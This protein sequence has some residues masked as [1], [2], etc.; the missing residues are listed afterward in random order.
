MTSKVP[1]AKVTENLKEKA[2]AKARMLAKA[3]LKATVPEVRA[4]SF[5]IKARV[6]METLA[7]LVTIPRT[8]DACL[9]EL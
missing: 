4:M 7:V 1:S 6:N 9:L 5:V 8:L 3:N 2:K